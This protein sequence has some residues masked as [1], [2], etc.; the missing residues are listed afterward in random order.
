MAVG[1]K[2]RYLRLVRRTFRLLRSP[3]LRRRPWLLK[4]LAPIFDRNLWHPCRENVA[5]GLSVGLFMAMLPMPGQMILAAIVGMQVRAN[6]VI[7]IA[8]CWVTNPLTQLF[9]MRQQELFGKFLK[10][11]LGFPDIPFF[12]D[13]EGAPP[14][15]FGVQLETMNAGSF[16]TGFI[17]SGVILAIL[18]FPLVYLLS[19]MMPNILPKSARHRRRTKVVIPPDPKQDQPS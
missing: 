9:V 18:A 8:A 3:R 11:K 14:E 2:T 12:S 4:I 6:V 15:M 19:A 7:A 1:L 5:S 16:I 10:E 13:L 17:M